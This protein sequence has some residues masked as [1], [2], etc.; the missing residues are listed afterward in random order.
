V[1]LNLLVNAAQA[2]NEGNAADN[3]IR[4]TTSTDASGIVI[5]IADTG[6]GMPPEVLNRLFTPFFT[7]KSAAPGTAF[8]TPPAAS[9][10][11]PHRHPAGSFRSDSLAA[12]AAVCHERTAASL[13]GVSP[14]G[15][16]GADS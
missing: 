1:C 2:I 5:Q 16:F 13:R 11:N 10:L 15:G 7:T 14:L 12:E 9:P 8:L 6:P 3:E 4:V